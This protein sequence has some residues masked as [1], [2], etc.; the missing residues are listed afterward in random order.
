[1]NSPGQEVPNTGNIYNGLQRVANAVNPS[2]AYLVPN[3][4]HPA[5]LAVP[6]GAPR[7]MYPSRGK[8][9][10]RVGFAYAL[11]TKTTVRGGFGV[12]YD[13]IQ[14][15][16]TFYTLNNPPYVGSAAYNYANL[17]NIRGGATVNA[18]W[19]TIQ[20]IDPN[21]Q[22]PYSEQFNFTIQRALPLKLFAEG[23]YVATLGR[24]L[25]AEPD[26]NQPTFAVLANIASTTNYNSIRRYAG[27]STIQQF[28]S[29]ATS[30]CHAMQ[31]RVARRVGTVKFTA[32]YTWSKNLTH[33]SSDTANDLNFYN[34]KLIYGPANSTS[35]AVSRDVRH[36]FVSTYVWDLP[37]LRNMNAIV[38]TPLGGWQL[39]GIIRLQRASTTRS[40]ATLRFSAAARPTTWLGRHC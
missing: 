35:G 4:N 34:L 14:G 10:P 30:N 13:R 39:S 6:A 31:L 7:G 19:G 23:G 27:D 32:A 38:R 3:A 36:A 26:I 21:L 9:Q 17:G 2:Q 12:F 29:A 22:T 37:R 8:F 16:P 15:N 33:A 28:I 1:M 11:D 40:Q 20:T 5:V 25:L 24:H 18:P